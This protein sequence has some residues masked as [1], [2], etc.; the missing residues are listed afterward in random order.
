[1]PSE[2]KDQVREILEDLILLTLLAAVVAATRLRLSVVE[3]V[4][5]LR[6]G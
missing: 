3:V 4:G 2:G 5:L 1:M 6:I